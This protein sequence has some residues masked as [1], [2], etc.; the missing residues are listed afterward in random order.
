[1]ASISINSN[2]AALNAQRQLG[3]STA[4]LR[5][6]YARLSSGLR[7]NKASDDAAG[8]AIA[9]SLNVDK[10]VTDQGIR[11]LN[12][13]ISMLS[14]AD[15]AL[16]QLENIVVR[17]SE[18]AEQASNGAIQN[19]QRKSLD[20]E[21]QALKTEFKRI[22]QTVGFNGINPLS[23]AAGTISLQAGAGS[24]N[25]VQSS[26]G[27]AT[28]SGLFGPA[29]TTSSTGIT[30][31][32]AAGD[33]N[34]DGNLDAVGW[35]A[36]G[37]SGVLTVALGD[38]QNG[39]TLAYTRTTASLAS[40]FGSI[41]LGDVNNDGV[42]DT[43][44]LGNNA[45]V[46]HVGNGDGTFKAP[47]SI[48]L[49]AITSANDITIADINN[50]GFLDI[51]AAVQYSSGAD[52]ASAYIILGN[53]NGTF[54]APYLYNNGNFGSSTG[55]SL[56]FTDVNND[57]QLDML[58]SATNDGAN[59]AYFAV[60][61]GN[62]DGQFKAVT[63][64]NTFS[65]SGGVLE[66]ADFN[67]DGFQDFIVTGSEGA[68]VYLGTGT[69]TF[70]RGTSFVPASSFLQAGDFNSDGNID[71]LA[72]NAVRL[73]NGNGT[74]AGPQTISL[75]LGT[76]AYA[77]GD[78]NGDG[79]LDLFGAINGGGTSVYAAVTNTGTA[80]LLDFSLATQAGARQA[81]SQFRQKLDSLTKQ[82]GKL[83]AY[84]ERI[85]TAI[86][87]NSTMALNVAAAAS[88]ISNADIAE[89][90]AQLVKQKILQQAGVAVLAQANQ[91]PGLALKLL[92]REPNS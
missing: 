38:G 57:G 3:R 10:R 81:I 67:N 9:S 18:L 34:G 52:D 53:G 19:T 37:G 4:G 11:N 73:G 16:E 80:P 59:G 33:V 6:S 55:N 61:L 20:A 17:L 43:V 31:G 65:V 70:T 23:A 60:R 29:S 15:G 47:L 35:G 56:A 49:S 27:G 75:A 48:A 72:G 66:N 87:N 1:L 58:E 64:T 76:Q 24:D 63:Y 69:G 71:I 68:F 77:V 8:L 32:V 39:Y 62:G 13:G 79:V 74:F 36:Q 5:D 28:G 50:D 2:V 7:I 85:E 92:Q 41:S 30:R 25:S 45:A 44:S 51:G 22:V 78:G 12:D 82:R 91:G 54:R 26:L 40:S 83:G 90:S 42:L 86:S 88:Q 89:E 21:G 46:I 14:I 84:Q